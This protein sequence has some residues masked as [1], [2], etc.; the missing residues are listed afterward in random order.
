MATAS[1]RWMGEDV[2]PRVEQGESRV[3]MAVVDPE[4]LEDLGEVGRLTWVGPC[5]VAAVLVAVVG[6]TGVRGA[7]YPAHEFR[8]EFWRRAAG[9]TWNFAWYGGHAVAPY[10]LLSPPV[11]SLLGTFLTV[12][13]STVVATWAFT[14]IA[15]AGFTDRIAGIA[16]YVFA[17]TASVDVV[18]GRVAFG[19]G[20]A[21]GLSTLVAWRRGAPGWAGLGA[22][23][24]ALAS[25]VAGAFLALGASSVGLSAL[26]RSVDRTTR[27]DRM[28]SACAIVAC[29]TVPI[30]VTSLTFGGEG[31]FPFRAGHLAVTLT[32][33]VLVGRFVP[34]IEVRVGCALAAASAVGL[35]VLPNAMGGN[36]VRLAQIVG[37]PLLVAGLAS[38]RKGKRSLSA[39]VAT[40]AVVVW[41]VSPGVV[42]AATW[43]GDRSVDREFHTPL[44]EEVARRNREGAPGRVE[45][46]FTVNHWEAAWV[47]GQVPFARGWERQLDLVRNPE[48]YDPDLDATTYRRWLDRNA[49]RWIAIPNAPIDRGGQPEVAVVLAAER[50]AATWTR[51]VWSDA[52]WTLYEVV[53]ARPIV[54]GAELVRFDSAELV[55]RVDGP[56]EVELRIVHSPTLTVWPAGCLASDGDGGV[57]AT[58]PGPGTYRIT[59]AFWD[60][61]H[62]QSAECAIG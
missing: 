42:A 60:A 9:S 26:R 11:V 51:R 57:R 1:T 21:I 24:T 12:A 49:V 15:R 43:H 46:P 47:A 14:T 8:A 62:S 4:Q 44:A 29:A 56:A 37:V 50:E 58:L 13:V 25:P 5:L 59:S 33:I 36:F 32:A 17:L 40:G 30:A 20:L 19:L 41:S 55:V 10:G 61:R 6:L 54:E 7:D 28:V 22:V 3:V 39:L 27:H 18:V 16:G 2:D 53:D 23:A 34:T 52:N 45:V 35:F 38:T 31:R 48:L